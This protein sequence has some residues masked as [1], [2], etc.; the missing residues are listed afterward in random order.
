MYMVLCFLWQWGDSQ[1]RIQ[2]YA[3][4]CFKIA[5]KGHTPIEEWADCRLHICLYRNAAWYE[6]LHEDT[7]FSILLN[8]LLPTLSET[9]YKFLHEEQEENWLNL[10]QKLEKQ[11]V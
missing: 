10:D 3:V 5:V 4:L 9:A 11:T 1:S 7:D 2:T 6:S 8:T